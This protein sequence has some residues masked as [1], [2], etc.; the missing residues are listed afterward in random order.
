VVISDKAVSW[1]EKDPGSVVNLILSSPAFGLATFRG[2]FDILVK[3]CGVEGSKGDWTTQ[4]GKKIIK[5]YSNSP[6]HEGKIRFIADGK[7]IARVRAVDET[8]PK[9]FAN[10]AAYLVRRV[11]MQT[12]KNAAE[13]YLDGVRV[14]RAAYWLAK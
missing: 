11:D 3:D 12:G 2:V 14:W 5:F 6:I 9:R 4:F 13:I 10:D 8:D 7:K 1:S